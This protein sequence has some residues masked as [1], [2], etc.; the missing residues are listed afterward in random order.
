MGV[1]PFV[2]EAT[3]E[4]DQFQRIA[5]QTNTSQMGT[6]DEIIV[7]VT[8]PATLSEVE[9]RWP[10]VQSCPPRIAVLRASAEDVQGVNGIVVF[11]PARLSETES[12]INPPLSESER[13]FVDAWMLGRKAKPSRKGEG[14]PWDTPG[15]SPP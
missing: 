14:L 6:G 1:I 4:V 5:E 13:L 2:I 10:I 7:A 15:F 11:D 8:R 3:I 9:Q 12:A